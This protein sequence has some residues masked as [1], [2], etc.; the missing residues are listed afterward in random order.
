MNAQY[1]VYQPPSASSTEPAGDQA[2]RR[3][4][5]WMIVV[6]FSN[7]GDVKPPTVIDVLPDRFSTREEAH[8]AAEQVAI[9]YRPPD[10]FAP[11]SR[12]VFADGPDGFL[13]IVQGAM[14]TFHF[15]TRVVQ[16]R[17]S[18]AP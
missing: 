1:D 4:G 12:D 17:G 7:E 8:Q 9:V 13:T 3:T 5:P 16:Y 18:T 14:S 2:G 10:P 6:E 15:S 11:Q